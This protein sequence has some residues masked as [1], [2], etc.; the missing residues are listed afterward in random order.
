LGGL[1]LRTSFVVSD[2][3]CSTLFFGGGLLG[4]TFAMTSS[5]LSSPL[6]KAS[7]A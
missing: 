6:M 5:A 4:L 3:T 1:T 2:T 7:V